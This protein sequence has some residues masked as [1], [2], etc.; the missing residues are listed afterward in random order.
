MFFTWPEYLFNKYFNYVEEFVPIQRLLK[1]EDLPLTLDKNY[2][3]VTA[4]LQ[5]MDRPSFC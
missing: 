5:D 1:L 2:V 4:F 3:D